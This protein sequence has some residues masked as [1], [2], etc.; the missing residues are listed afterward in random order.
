MGNQL[1]F[2]PTGLSP[3][4]FNRLTE[5]SELASTDSISNLQAKV[6]DH[7]S[8]ARVA[9]ERNRLLN[10]ALASAIGRVLDELAARWETLPAASRYWLAGAFLYFAKCDD[11]EPDFRSPIGFEDD[12]EVL[13]ACLRFAKLDELC[14]RVEDYD[15]A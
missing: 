7:L 4:Q 14:L 3:S 6:S 11:E 1:D 10:L 15:H 13:N 2:D 12:A 9:F 5:L 8:R